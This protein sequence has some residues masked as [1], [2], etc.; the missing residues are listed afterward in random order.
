MPIL[1]TLAEQVADARRAHDVL[2]A[3]LKRNGH[4]QH[5]GNLAWREVF[6]AG[7]V[8]LLLLKRGDDSDDWM[9]KHT[10]VDS[11]ETFVVLEGVLEIC[12]GVNERCQRVPAGATFAVPLGC[13]HRARVGAEGP[14]LGITVLHP[15]E[16]SYCD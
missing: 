14:L 3:M 11:R 7:G 8:Q 10:H 6:N 9:P 12:L 4:M 15:P 2:S 13:E 16:E 5:A 1:D